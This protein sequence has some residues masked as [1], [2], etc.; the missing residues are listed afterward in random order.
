MSSIEIL[1]HRAYKGCY[2]ENTLLAFDKAYEAGVHTIETDI[3]MTKDGVVVINHDATTGRIFDQDLVIAETDY[4]ELANLRCKSTEYRNEK[5]PTLVDALEWAVKHPNVQ[6][7]ID[8]KFTNEKIILIKTL[9]DMLRVKNDVAYWQQRIVWG[10]WTL[11]W[12]Q[13]G[14]ETGV[15]KDFRFIV[16]S[17]SLEIAKQFVEYSKRLD[18]DHYRLYGV[19]LHY[20]CSWITQ[21]QKEWFP[22]LRKNGLKVYLWTVNSEPDFKY[23]C[24][25]PIDGAITDDP[26][27]ARQLCQQYKKTPENTFKRPY[28]NSKEGFRFYGFI[29][30]YKLVITLLFSPWSHYKILGKWSLAQ[31]LFQILKL[32]HFL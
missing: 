3:Q 6:L 11:D 18:N 26:V 13:F 32:I 15:L 30:V 28:F 31:L 17:L 10:L 19:S 29:A 25:L 24:S 21:F 16:I 9:G 27:T 22:Y 12:Y 14:V 1:G 2:P 8:I 5:L 23:L 4:S 20:V 7:M